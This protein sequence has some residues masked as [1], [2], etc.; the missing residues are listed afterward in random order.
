M[1]RLLI[2]VLILAQCIETFGQISDSTDVDIV[3]LLFSKKK[4]EAASVQRSNKKV[5]FSLLPAAVNVPG[6]GKAVITAVNAAF[7]AGDPT[8]TNLS[9]VYIIPYTNFTNRYG[10][11]VRPN[12]WLPH[13]KF[14]LIADWRI[15]HFPQYSWGLGGNSPEWDESLIDSDYLR[16]YQT[17]LVKIFNHWFAGLGYYFDH[18]YD[19]SE[20]EYVGEGH[21]GR[22]GEGGVTSTTSSGVTVNF[23][24]D[25]RTNAIN[26]QRGAYVALMIRRNEDW[27]GSTYTNSSLF[28]DARKYIRFSSVFDRVLAVR[29]YYWT[30]LRGQTPYLDLPATNWA[31]ATGIAS[32]GFQTG[33][34]R[35]NAM[36][37]FE[38]E[39][40]FQ[41]T[42][43]GLIGVVAF[44]NLSSA[45]EFDTQHFK[46]WQ[47]GAGFGVRIKMNKYSDS[48]IAVDMGFSH[49]YWGVWLNIGE[50][51]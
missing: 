3:D 45:S 11:Y 7:Y 6:G 44:L 35:S 19:I 30:V 49:N 20:S 38:G 4:R 50:V 39:Q 31:P 18:R 21:L 41:L 46:T 26:P 28:A 23:V 16:L 2:I 14:N 9:N 10:L 36:L 47:A 22:Y 32:R 51:F 29:T 5:H 13:N 48:N 37:Y 24:Y 25:S 17:A 42:P 34:Y 27:L 15:A 1:A 33:R 40:R 12:I 43:N 8:V